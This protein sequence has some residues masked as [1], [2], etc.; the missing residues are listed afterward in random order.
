[1]IDKLR[2]VIAVNADNLIPPRSADKNPQDAGATK[3]DRK[4]NVKQ[5]MRH[6]LL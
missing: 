4:E 2:A 3:Q 1:M 5:T 6:F